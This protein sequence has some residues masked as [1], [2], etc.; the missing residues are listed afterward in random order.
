MDAKLSYIPESYRAHL[1][2]YV[3]IIRRQSSQGPLFLFFEEII[4][5]ISKIFSSF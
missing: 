2:I 5:I 1:E 4:C 3:I